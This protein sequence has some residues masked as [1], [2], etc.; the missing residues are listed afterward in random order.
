[1]PR[2]T[3]KL[4]TT[5]TLPQYANLTLGGAVRWQSDVS[6]A[7]LGTTV[8]QDAYTVVDLLAAIDLTD[9]VRATVNA[10]N[11]FDETYYG[12]LQWTQAFYAP[13]RSVMVTVDY[14]F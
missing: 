3:L 12:S 4:N 2:Q 13:P 11:V 6:T 7:D 5:Y 9:H 8:T 1:V 10:K 14:R